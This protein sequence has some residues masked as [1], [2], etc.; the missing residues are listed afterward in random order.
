MPPVGEAT[1]DAGARLPYRV[2]N[3]SYAKP[4]SER[5]QAVHSLTAAHVVE[6]RVA[7]PDL[8]IAFA[9]PAA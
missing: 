1:A 4:A 7:S 6:G 3:D 9:R 2:E 5:F 8:Y